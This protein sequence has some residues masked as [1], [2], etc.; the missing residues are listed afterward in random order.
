MRNTKRQLWVDIYEP[1]FSFD[2]TTSRGKTY[3]VVELFEHSMTGKRLVIKI[4]QRSR[5][6]VHEVHMDSILTNVFDY[7]PKLDRN[8][9]HKMLAGLVKATVRGWA[10]YYLPLGAI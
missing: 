9:A 1:T 7:I 3:A 8:N 6:D 2:L 5:W 10:E 4:R